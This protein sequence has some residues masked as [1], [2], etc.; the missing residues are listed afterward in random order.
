M[1]VDKQTNRRTQTQQH[2][3]NDNNDDDWRLAILLPTA[4]LLC[5]A[6]PQCFLPLQMPSPD[7]W[8]WSPNLPPTAGVPAFTWAQRLH[9]QGNTTKEMQGNCC[10]TAANCHICSRLKTASGRCRSS[11][12][13]NLASIRIHRTASWPCCQALS[14]IWTSSGPRKHHI[15]NAPMHAKSVASCARGFGSMVNTVKPR[16]S[17]TRK[18]FA[19][20]RRHKYPFPPS[21]FFTW[22]TVGSSRF[23]LT[24]PPKL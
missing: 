24:E 18:E 1:A 16:P 5:V 9:V 14:M 3:K 13:S 23:P 19:K 17:P 12:Q 11:S 21:A 10:S 8:P 7:D 4:L 22:R 2:G 6:R 15:A 20:F